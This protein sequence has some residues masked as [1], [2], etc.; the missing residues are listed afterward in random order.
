MARKKR[1][2]AHDGPAAKAPAG[3]R[4]GAAASGRQAAPGK[5]AAEA[6]GG[7]K[8]APYV[9]A[10]AFLMVICGYALLRWADPGGR[11][12]WSVVSP[13]F[14]LAGY[15]LFIPAISLTFRD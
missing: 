6:A 11:N 3:G 4:D 10:A 1:R 15:L 9:W 8:Y 14:L 12:G 13:A 2:P 7:S 5:G